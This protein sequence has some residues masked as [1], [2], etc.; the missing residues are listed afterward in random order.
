MIVLLA[1]QSHPEQYHKLKEETFQIIYGNM[2]LRLD[3]IDRSCEAG[4]IITIHRGVRHEFTTKT[5]VV[6][7]E[8]SSKHEAA[9][10]YYTNPRS[11]PTEAVRR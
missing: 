6:I 10:S 5:G 11:R 2:Q 8:I 9:D 7:E 3:G 1:G 4:D